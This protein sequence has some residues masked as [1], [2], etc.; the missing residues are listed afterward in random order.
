VPLVR[1]QRV[2]IDDDV[3]G[4]AGGRPLHAS[5]PGR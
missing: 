3:E 4:G 5:Q 2:L 1:L